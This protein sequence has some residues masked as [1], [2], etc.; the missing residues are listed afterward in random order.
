MSYT[1]IDNEAKKQYEFHIDGDLARIEYI[2]A[3]G[4]IFLTHTEVPEKFEGKG[5]GSALAK[6]ALDDIQQ[7]GLQLVPLCPFVSAYLNRHPE[8]NSLIESK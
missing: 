7:K 5:I 3:Q 4:K 8:Y 2:K 6:Q 1:L